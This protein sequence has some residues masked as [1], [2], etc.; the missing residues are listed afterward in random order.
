MTPLIETLLLGA[1]TVLLFGYGAGQRHLKKRLTSELELERTKNA[2]ALARHE[3]H[4]ASLQSDITKSREVLE[5]IQKRKNEEIEAFDAVKKQKTELQE[6][7]ATEDGQA[8]NQAALEKLAQVQ[9][10][11]QA[12]LKNRDD[13]N[14]LKKG[15]KLGSAPHA[16][17][18]KI[19][20]TLRVLAPECE[21]VW[22]L[23]PGTVL[24]IEGPDGIWRGSTIAAL[25]AFIDSYEGRTWTGKGTALLYL[26]R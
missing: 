8:A 1:A 4:L 15:T 18:M 12:S 14:A 26:D 22:K 7:L 25:Q 2:N 16:A 13:I 3:E 20:P 21:R 19:Q 24:T 5:A 10:E 11:V 9:A 6:Y 17:N 23:A